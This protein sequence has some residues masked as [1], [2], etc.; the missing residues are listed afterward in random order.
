MS[1][2]EFD[3]V[4]VGAGS[5]GCVLANRLTA[6][7]RT[8]LQL[9]EAGGSDRTPFVQVP[10]GAVATLPRKFHN[11][12]Y[13]TVP[14]PGLGG[15]RGYQPRGKVLG[16]SSSINAMIYARGHRTDYDRWAA[17]GN[18]GW[19]WS[20]VFPYFLRAEDNKAFGA[21]H[22]GQGGPLTVSALRTGNPVAEAFVRAGEQCGHRRNPDFNGEDQE[23]VGH[24]QVTQRD[25]LRCSASKAYLDPALGRPN[26][27]VATGVHATRVLFEGR[28]AV[29]VEYVR[30]GQ[31]S[32]VRARRE[33]ILSAGAFGSPQLLMLSGVGPGDELSRHGIAA[34]HALP[35]VGANLHDHPDFVFAWKSDST[36]LIGFAPRGVLRLVREFGRFRREQA[37]MLT[38]NFAEAGGFLRTSPEEPVPDVQLHF[39]VAIV[40]DHARK[41]NFALGFSCHVC[42]LRPR[43]R[44]SL[45]LA[46]SDPMQDPLIDPAFLADPDDV[47][48]LVRG[49]ELTRKIVEAPALAPYRKQEL[50]SAGVTRDDDIRALLRAR[51]DTVYHP[52]G[53]CRMGPDAD[54]VVDH[55]L[56]VHGIDGL[57]VVD[58]SVMPEVIGGNTNAPTIMIAEKASDLILG[59]RP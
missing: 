30:G 29:G 32:V 33:V 23:G 44:G 22:H 19:A 34:V 56:R 25:G 10:V 45:R 7:G 51:V 57:R 8:T 9:L 11:W 26:L 4:V 31:R 48:R 52:V 47:E 20:D 53:T 24:F 39:V 54:A 6:D 46:G 49:F 13:Q 16:G 38:S 40:E 21:P 42:L 41:L 15:R 36:E 28:R 35:G 14:Q 17:A 59:H 2:Q 50:W 55:E 3:F 27:S 37:G 5:A 1:E 12:G 18:P 43:S 58:A